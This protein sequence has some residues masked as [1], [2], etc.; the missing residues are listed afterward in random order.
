MTALCRL[1]GVTRAGFYAW[2]AR[3]ASAHTE[4]DRR[5]ETARLAL[6]G[7]TDVEHIESLRRRLGGGAA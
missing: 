6:S 3:P 4:Q 1:Y 5:L 2:R 7:E